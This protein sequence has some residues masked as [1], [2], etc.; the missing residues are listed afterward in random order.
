MISS[1]AVK[2]RFIEKLSLPKFGR[3]IAVIA[4]SV[5][6][7]NETGF[8]TIETSKASNQV[9]QERYAHVTFHKVYDLSS[10]DYVVHAKPDLVVLFGKYIVDPKFK[11]KIWFAEYFTAHGLNFT[12]S[13]RRVPEIESNKSDSIAKS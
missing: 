11:S 8:G 4:A 7:L 12:E 1:K 6:D 5:D 3:H 10:L 9:L 2:P 13:D